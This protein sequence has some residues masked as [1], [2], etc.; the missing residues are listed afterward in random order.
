MNKIRNYTI[1]LAVSLA[2]ASDAM[3]HSMTNIEYKVCKDRIAAEYLVD[4][5][6]C[7]I[8][9]DNPNDL[10][11]DEAKSKEKVARTELDDDY[12]LTLQTHYQAD[13]ARATA[14][15][16]AA[17]ARCDHDKNGSAK[18]AC[19]KEAKIAQSAAKNDAKARLNAPD[20]S[21]A[22]SKKPAAT[23][24]RPVTPAQACAADVQAIMAAFHAHFLLKSGA[25]PEH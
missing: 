5:A 8:F 9:S 10:C 6:D 20:A 1:T 11:V 4:K 15:F 18:A 3:A 23:L 19:I 7:A 25:A 22:A 17:Q 21:D 24:G 2:F 14:G 13:I 12:K 16:A